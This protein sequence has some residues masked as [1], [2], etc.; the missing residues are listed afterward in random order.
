MAYINEIRA[1][2]AVSDFVSQESTAVHAVLDKEL[3][4]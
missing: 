2:K 4:L 1:H 3:E